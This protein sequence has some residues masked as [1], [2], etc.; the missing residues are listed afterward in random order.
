[1]SAFSLIAKKNEHSF[2]TEYELKL[3]IDCN[4]SYIKLLI[5]QFMN[6]GKLLLKWLSIE[7]RCDHFPPLIT[8]YALK[9]FET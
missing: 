5:V 9:T 7:L 4:T 8:V 2:L 3:I 6:T 1:M